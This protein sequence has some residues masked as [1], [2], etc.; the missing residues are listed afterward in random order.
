VRAVLD[1]ST[2]APVSVEVPAHVI[3]TP[4]L[5][6][7]SGGDRMGRVAIVGPTAVYLELA[8]VVVGLTARG[9]PLMPNGIALGVDGSNPRGVD[10]TPWSRWIAALVRPGDPARLG[11]TGID[12]GGVHVRWPW[13]LPVWEPAVPARRWGR[14]AVLSRGEGILRGAGVGSMTSPG[15][16]ARA[17]ARDGITLARDPLGR[18]AIDV[19]FE[20]LWQ[21]DPEVACTAA[22]RLLGLGAGLTPEGDDLLAASALSITALGPSVGLGD[23]ARRRLVA[24][25]VP[26]PLGRTTSLSATLLALAAEG[27]AMEP[28]AHL[29]DLDDERSWAGAFDRL[30]RVGHTTGVVYAIGVGTTAVALARGG[31]SEDGPA[32]SG[33]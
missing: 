23:R 17:M 27:R 14:D 6:W 31:S 4:V 20:S 19:L 12:A 10:P 28:V 26:E 7:A 21:R 9:V 2:F 22:L 13:P 5:E 15:G 32:G 8:G 18:R 25:L 11:S 33:G 24:A 3:A 1:R 30:S 16:V 29:L